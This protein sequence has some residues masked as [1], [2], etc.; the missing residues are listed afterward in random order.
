MSNKINSHICLVYKFSS[1]GQ[2]WPP[3]KPYI[4]RLNWERNLNFYEGQ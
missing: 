3:K 1:N 4:T 2:I